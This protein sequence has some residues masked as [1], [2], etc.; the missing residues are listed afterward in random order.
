MFFGLIYFLNNSYKTKFGYP[1]NNIILV[2]LSCHSSYIVQLKCIKAFHDVYNSLMDITYHM[3][4]G[5]YLLHV[6]TGA[7]VKCYCFYFNVF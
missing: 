5:H 1:L 2:E 4:Y 7:Y 3:Y 6:F